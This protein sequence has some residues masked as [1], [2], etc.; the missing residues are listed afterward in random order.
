MTGLPLILG[1]EVSDI[2]FPIL[3]ALT[4]LAF[5]MIVGIGFAFVKSLYKRCSSNQVLV[6]YGAGTGR[7][8]ATSKTVHGGGSFVWPVIQSYEYLSLEPIQIEIPLRG[9]SRSRI[10]ASTCRACLPWPLVPRLR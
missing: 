1:V 8:G 4:I 7:D 10:F 3:V 9:C 6:V 2:P 5:M